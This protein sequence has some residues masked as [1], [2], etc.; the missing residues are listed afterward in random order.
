VTTLHGIELKSEELFGESA[1]WI[2]FVAVEG[3]KGHAFEGLLEAGAHG[4]TKEA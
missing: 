1:T 3:S 2:P 4:M